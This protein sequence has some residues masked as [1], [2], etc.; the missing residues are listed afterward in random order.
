MASVL[1]TAVTHP[2][3]AALCAKAYP[4]AVAWRTKGATLL[5]LAS[6]ERGAELVPDA[7]PC[8]HQNMGCLRTNMG[9]HCK[10]LVTPVYMHEF[11]NL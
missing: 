6:Y 11:H 5:G 1:F 8:D 3:F 2:H 4:Q 9:H 10:H 7:E